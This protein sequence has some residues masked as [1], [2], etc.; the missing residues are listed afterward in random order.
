MP[1]VMRERNGDC[2]YVIFNLFA[3][4]RPY[5]ILASAPPSN[6]NTQLK[7]DVASCLTTKK[8]AFWHLDIV[9]QSYLYSYNE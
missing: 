6:N 3:V 2:V 9:E 4:P 7:L 1:H 8:K 5:L